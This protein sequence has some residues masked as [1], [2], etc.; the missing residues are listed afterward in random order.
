MARYT[1][2]TLQYTAHCTV[3]YNA[4]DAMFLGLALSCI[5]PVVLG[6]GGWLGRLH[7]HDTGEAGGIRGQVQEDHRR[8]AGMPSLLYPGL[9]TPPLDRVLPCSSSSA[10]ELWVGSCSSSFAAPHE[11]QSETAG[12][13]AS[14][15]RGAEESTDYLATLPL[16]CHQN[17]RSCSWLHVV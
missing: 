15:R 7:S 8:R 6:A 17:R 4:A 12:W 10:E 1:V 9:P 2:C 13:F 14:R 11:W 5:P 16:G 3:Q